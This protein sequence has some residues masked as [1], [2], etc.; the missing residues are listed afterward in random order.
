ME[1]TRLGLD[2]DGAEFARGWLV[3]DFELE[4]ESLTKGRFDKAAGLLRGAAGTAWL[5]LPCARPPIHIKPPLGRLDLSNL[6]HAV[7]VVS[8]VLH[9]QTQISL[10][11]AQ[12][13]KPGAVLGDTVAVDLAA[14]PAEL[15]QIV[16]HGRGVGDWLDT[17]P[18][19][20]RFAVEFS[21]VTVSLEDAELAVGRVIDGSVTYPI[22]DR[23]RGPIEIVIEGFV[24]VISALELTPKR[25]TAVAEV[26]LPGGLVDVQ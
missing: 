16:Q 23:F 10:H 1:R 12:R 9:P 11:D 20:A 7:E 14:S 5:R 19:I 22:A 2:V 25:S 13:I 24:L 8:E 4:V 26:R 17:D 21:D 18:E 3:G 6:T 15:Q